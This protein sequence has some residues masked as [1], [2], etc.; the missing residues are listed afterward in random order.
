MPNLF[1]NPKNF[2]VVFGENPV[3]EEGFSDFT[4][5]FLCSTVFVDVKNVQVSSFSSDFKVFKSYR[6][7]REVVRI[8]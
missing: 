4:L 5:L 8:F 6:F 7:F 2:C 3:R 1:G